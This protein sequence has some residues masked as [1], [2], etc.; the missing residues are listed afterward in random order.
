MSARDLPIFITEAAR[1]TTALWLR[2]V[3]AP[4]VEACRFECAPPPLGV[5]PVG[6]W[7]GI[8][9]SRTFAPDRRVCVSSKLVF[10]TAENIVSVYLHECCHRLLESQ[11][12]MQ[13]RP[14]FFCLNA[15]LLLR[16]KAAFESDPIFKLDLY[17]MQDCPPELENEPAW[18]GVVLN[19]ALPLA[20][21]LAA[22]DAGAEA[23]ADIVCARWS[24]FAQ[25]REN[26]HVAAAQQVI[27][28]RKN[29][30]L[31]LEKIEDLQSS[32]FVART[33]L[34]VGWVCFVVSVY[35]VSL[36]M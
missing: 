31:Q 23:L 35:F 2:R 16:S 4:V 10:W 12:G 6:A 9:D 28:A 20:A 3:L 34:I 8:C 13:H 25:E 27:A 29:A 14:E 1:A 33:F 21:E 15:V 7:A 24:A 26:A 36:T 30:A 22:T 32:L 17:D 18:R 11:I 5:R 19:W